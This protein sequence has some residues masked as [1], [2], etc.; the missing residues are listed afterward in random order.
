MHVEPWTAAEAGVRA[1]ARRYGAMLVFWLPVA[2]LELLI[3][4]LQTTLPTPPP[5]DA[6]ALVRYAGVL[7]PLAL[8]YELVYLVFAGASSALVVHERAGVKE[9]FGL[10]RLRGAR[11]AGSAALALVVATAFA[12]PA[13]VVGA[14]LASALAAGVDIAL[15]TALFIL[16]PL[17]VWLVNRMLF[18]LPATA[19]DGLS[20]TEALRTSRDLT[21]RE[22]TLGFAL[23]VVLVWGSLALLSR[24][25]AALALGALSSVTGAASSEVAVDLL[26]EPVHWLTMPFVPAM[27]ASYYA[28]LTR[29]AAG[30]AITERQAPA[31]RET[32]R[33][34]RCPSCATVIPYEATGSETRV[35][36]PTCGRT[37]VV[38]AT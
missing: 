22:R 25:A 32:F 12:L 23:L 1:A 17:A 30:P 27:A 4:L 2:L 14:L 34:T 3:V 33:M 15:I 26:A 13:F 24:A 28:M 20:P 16:V 9:A 31:K 38:R 8:A 11:L 5:G 35:S 29:P 36:C 10:L 7:A 37:G 19:L 21:R 6:A 18:L